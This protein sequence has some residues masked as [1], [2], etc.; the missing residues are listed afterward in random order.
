[1]SGLSDWLFG[2]GALKK[3]ASTG[4]SNAP[5][6]TGP[7]Q[8]AGLDM[9][10]LAQDSADRQKSQ[11]TPAATKPAKT[12]SPLSTTMTPMTPSKKAK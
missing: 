7:A 11:S 1:M 12:S 6:D 8:P 10:R 9:A 3:A 5:K 2:S 4:D